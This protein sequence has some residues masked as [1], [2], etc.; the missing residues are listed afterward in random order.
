LGVAGA[1]RTRALGETRTLIPRR[2]GAKEESDGQIEDRDEK[3]FVLFELVP[4]GVA[5]FIPKGKGGRIEK[6][7][8]GGPQAVYTTYDG[9][10]GGWRGKGLSH[11]RSPRKP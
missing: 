11:S 9:D 3:R 8:G 4:R 10:F 7:P 6:G 2:D 5:G 1:R